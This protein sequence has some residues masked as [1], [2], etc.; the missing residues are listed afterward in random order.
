MSKGKPNSKYPLNV[1]VTD[2]F[3]VTYWSL[4]TLL[5]NDEGVGEA[6]AIYPRDFMGL[7]HMRCVGVY[8]VG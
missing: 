8:E 6:S 5:T 2:P 1:T 7:A 4:V 3:N